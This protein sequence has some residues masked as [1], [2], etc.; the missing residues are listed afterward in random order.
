MTYRNAA[1]QWILTTGL[2]LES[3]VLVR[4]HVGNCFD[5]A[6]MTTLVWSFTAVTAEEPRDP[7]IDLVPTGCVMP[8]SER[9][10]CTLITK[11]KERNPEMH[12]FDG[13]PYL[14]KWG[15]EGV[16]MRQSETV[17]LDKALAQ[18]EWVRSKI[19]QIATM[20]PQ[21]SAEKTPRPREWRLNHTGQWSEQPETGDRSR[22][23]RPQDKGKGG[24]K[25]MRLG[26]KGKKSGN[27][28]PPEGEE[29]ERSGRR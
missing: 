11:E 20:T 6:S 29:E 21:H 13:E 7:I 18:A 19:K 8:S 28:A 14:P 10:H 15:D 16:S 2:P 22:T 26:R 27:G 25:G 12:I 1:N 5:V 23:P 4:D 3:V 9:W 24:S 17:P